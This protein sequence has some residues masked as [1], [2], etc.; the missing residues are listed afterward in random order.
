MA[1]PSD[2]AAAVSSLRRGRRA[3]LSVMSRRNINTQGR[4]PKVHSKTRTAGA[5][6]RFNIQTCTLGGF[7]FRHLSERT[8]Q[9]AP[10]H[11]QVCAIHTKGHTDGIAPA[12]VADGWHINR[13]AAVPTNHVLPVLAVAFR[14]ANPARIQRN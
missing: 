4:K 10:I 2:S 14:S 13:G 3:K 7:S 1:I 11:H 9:R 6:A 8:G 12:R 5:L